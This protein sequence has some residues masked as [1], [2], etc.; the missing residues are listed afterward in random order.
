MCWA[1]CG[2]AYIGWLALPLID[3]FR[4]VEIGL[5]LFAAVLC[6][7]LYLIYRRPHPRADDIVRPG[8][9]EELEAQLA[10]ADEI[11]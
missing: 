9:P 4:R 11:R 1:A 7:L 3:E 5:A 2:I 8:S 10:A 6:G